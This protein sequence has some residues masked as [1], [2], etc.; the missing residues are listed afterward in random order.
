MYSANKMTL[1]KKEEEILR[2]TKR[3]IMRY[4]IGT[5]N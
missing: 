4:H 1:T 3:K 2:I 5:E